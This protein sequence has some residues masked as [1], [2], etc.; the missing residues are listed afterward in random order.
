MSVATWTS[1]RLRNQ[2]RTKPRCRSNIANAIIDEQLYGSTAGALQA[3]VSGTNL[4]L[5]T[6]F[7]G[8]NPTS[9]PT[10][11]VTSPQP[12]LRGAKTPYS[13]QAS[14]G[15]A[16]ELPFNTMLTMDLTH[17]RVYDDWIALSGN[18]LENPANPEQNLNPTSAMSSTIYG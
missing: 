2:L 12:V 13:F 8:Q 7:A 3:T 17:V 5:P 6:P 9:N 1:I 4:A 11:Y 15:F 10:N 14:F 16:R 18:L